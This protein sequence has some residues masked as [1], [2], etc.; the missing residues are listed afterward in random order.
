LKNLSREYCSKYGEI[1]ECVIMRDRE[2][3]SR[4]FAFVS[5]K[6]LFIELILKSIIYVL[7]DRTMV[8][9]FMTHR[10]HTIDGRQTEPK[11]AMPRDEAS[12]PEGQLTVKKV[13][14][15]GIKEELTEDD[16]K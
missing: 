11:R 14:I 13:F 10:P 16:L 4:G 6:G 2:G 7:K 3:R 15:G 8:D 1:T 12:R 5:F 9:D